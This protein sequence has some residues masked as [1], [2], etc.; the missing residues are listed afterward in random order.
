[1]STA[2]FVTGS[3]VSESIT[4]MRRVSGMPGL[5]SVMSWRILSASM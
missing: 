1:M 3:Q 2:A 5:S 4:L